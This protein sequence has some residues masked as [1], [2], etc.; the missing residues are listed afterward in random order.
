M[1]SLGGITVVVDDVLMGT[2]EAV[3][4]V[5]SF[6]TGTDDTLIVLL[7]QAGK[8]ELAKNKTR[9][10]MILFIFIQKFSVQKIDYSHF[11]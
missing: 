9:K 6:F 11:K 3:D 1:T 8:I 2:V 4:V 5:F 10:I 7:P